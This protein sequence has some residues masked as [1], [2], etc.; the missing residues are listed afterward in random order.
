[1]YTVNHI[2]WIPNKNVKILFFCACKLDT[3]LKDGKC[4][5]KTLLLIYSILGNLSN[6]EGLN[7]TPP[8]TEIL[9]TIIVLIIWSM[10]CLAFRSTWV[11]SRVSNLHAQKNRIFTFL[12]GIQLM[13]FT[14]YIYVI[15]S[16]QNIGHNKT[17]RCL[18]NDVH[19]TDWCIRLYNEMI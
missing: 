11:H 14:V 2:N 16:I 17:N 5:L 4:V 19:F 3:S 13:W 15:R 7:S 6:C 12:F 1:M 8:H 18:E 10:N 9:V